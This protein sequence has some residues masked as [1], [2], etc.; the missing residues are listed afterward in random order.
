ML[1]ASVLDSFKRVTRLGKDVVSCMTL[2]RVASR[3]A[4]LDCICSVV[5]LWLHRVKKRFYLTTSFF[6][7]LLYL[8]AQSE[9]SDKKVPGEKFPKLMEK[10]T[11]YLNPVHF[12]ILFF[13]FKV[14]LK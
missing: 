11:F 13:D 3:V 10:F 4:L 5:N 6:R 1:F 9:L 12:F 14:R 2:S 7:L 8:N